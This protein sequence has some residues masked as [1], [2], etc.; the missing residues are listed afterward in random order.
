M[1]V[2]TRHRQVPRTKIQA[3][4]KFKGP[5]SNFEIGTYLELVSWF[6]ELARTRPYAAPCLEN[7]SRDL[8][9]SAFIEGS[10]GC[11]SAGQTSPW[12]RTNWNA[13]RTR[14]VS[15]TLRPTAR[16]LIVACWTMPS[17]SMMNS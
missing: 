13:W 6:L 12:A 3:P 15:S 2:K 9:Q 5:N 7:H 8:T 11:Q 16:L 4:N 10:P 14:M 17:G 1:E